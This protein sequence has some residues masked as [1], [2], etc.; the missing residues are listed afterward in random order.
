MRTQ[1]LTAI[2]VHYIERGNHQGAG[3]RPLLA[4]VAKGPPSAQRPVLVGAVAGL[5]PEEFSRILSG[6]GELKRQTANQSAAHPT[7][8]KSPAAKA[9]M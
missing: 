5:E 2:M 8:D 6:G 3:E 4:G 1:A 7:G 9:M